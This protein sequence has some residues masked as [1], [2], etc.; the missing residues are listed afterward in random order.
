MRDKITF[1]IVTAYNRTNASFEEPSELRILTNLVSRDLDL[2]DFMMDPFKYVDDIISGEIEEQGDILA[3][4]NGPMP[5][6]L[7]KSML[8]V[9]V[10]NE[11]VN[12]IVAD[13]AEGPLSIVPVA[14]TYADV[15]VMLRMKELLPMSNSFWSQ[16][17]VGM[18]T[19]KYNG[20]P[21]MSGRAYELMVDIHAV[22]DEEPDTIRVGKIDRDTWLS[23]ASN[24]ALMMGQ[25]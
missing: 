4:W 14:G 12:E 18:D 23:K 22:L 6:L 25:F 11:S 16:F 17:H 21:S 15:D 20:K 3:Q 7:H 1:G 10:L 24:Y 8:I 9:R 2:A 13:G 5:T 19:K